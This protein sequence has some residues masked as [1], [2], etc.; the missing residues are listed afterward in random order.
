[1]KGDEIMNNKKNDNKM[2][3]TINPETGAKTYKKTLT[4]YVGVN[5][6]IEKASIHNIITKPN[7]F[8]IILL[9]IFGAGKDFVPLDN[10]TM[11]SHFYE[12]FLF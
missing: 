1:M 11:K 6:N 3:Y 10:F 7:W 12:I 9:I 4:A 2:S 8:W 5:A